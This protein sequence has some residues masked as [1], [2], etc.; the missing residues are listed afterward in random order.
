MF[1]T[2]EKFRDVIWH[3]DVHMSMSVVPFQLDTTVETT[4]PIFLEIVVLV[5][6]LYQVV[7]IVFADVFDAEV[8]YG[9]CELDRS[10]DMFPK[11]WC[12]LDLIVSMRA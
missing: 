4:C 9:E 12:V 5:Q 6:G 2:G 3:A 1:E 11:A 7:C 8:V 10:G